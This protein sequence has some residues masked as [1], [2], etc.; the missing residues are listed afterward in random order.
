[1]KRGA[2]CRLS[3][4]MFAD[5]VLFH[6]FTL[7][8]CHL[9][10]TK[11]PTG[12]T[13]L[14]QLP[15]SPRAVL[16]Q[17]RRSTALPAATTSSQGSTTAMVSVVVAVLRAPGRRSACGKPWARPL[18][19]IVLSRNEHDVAV[20][21]PLDAF[22]GH[23]H[24]LLLVP[25]NDLARGR[26]PRRA[27]GP[28]AVSISPRTWPRAVAGPRRLR[29]RR[30]G[31]RLRDPPSGGSG[32]PDHDRGRLRVLCRNVGVSQH[33][34][35]SGNTND[36]ESS[37]PHRH[38]YAPEITPHKGGEQREEIGGCSPSLERLD[39]GVGSPRTGFAP[40][41]PWAGIRHP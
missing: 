34:R 15:P 25:E 7:S 2:P 28:A 37:P 20:A 35:V 36:P 40:P 29:P 39:R 22:A 33:E 30:R 17:F 18:A 5:A 26:R 41:R 14:P 32:R 16:Q 38:E 9:V 19:K 10:I 21:L 12:P 6:L 24:G 27:A 23:D 4:P 11:A 31:G 3:S 1:V 13:Y 8:P